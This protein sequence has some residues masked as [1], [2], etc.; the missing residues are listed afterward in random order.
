MVNQRVLAGTYGQSGKA[1]GPKE[2]GGVR[3]EHPHLKAQKRRAMR[4]AKLMLEAEMNMARQICFRRSET[5]ANIMHRIGVSVSNST[6]VHT[7][8][9]GH[10]EIAD[11]KCMIGAWAR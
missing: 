2:V 9:F 1:L 3:T 8:A 11:R 10:G 5:S 4:E 6:K 7:D